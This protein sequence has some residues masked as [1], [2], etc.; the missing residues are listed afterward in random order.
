MTTTNPTYPGVYVEEASTSV[1]A[2]TAAPTAVTAFVGHTRRGPLNHPVTVT[3]FAEFERHF[4]RLTKNSPVGYAVHQYFGN[5]GGSAVV[6]R[7]IE[8]GSAKAACRTLHA[9]PEHDQC[10]VLEVRA[11][12]PGEWGSVLRIVVDYPARDPYDTF[13]LRVLDAR[14]R[15][16]ERFR[17]L[18]MDPD[19]RRYVAAVVNS[20]STLIRVAVVGDHRPAPSGTVSRVFDDELPDLDVELTVAIGDVKRTFTLY[21]PDCDGRPPR[22]LTELALLLE[23]KLRALPDRPRRHAF[24]RAQVSRWG[25]RLRT[26][27]GSTDERDVVRFSGDCTGD[28]GLDEW[29]SPPAVAL[30]G[31]ADGDLP[32]PRDLIGDEAGKTGIQALRDV[33]DVNLLCLP[34]LA[35]YESADD[36]TAVLSAAGRLC[37]ERRMFM[38]VDAPEDWTSVDAARAGI[39]EFEPV[40]DDHSALFFPQLMLDDPLTG[41]LRAFPPCGAVAGVIARTDAERGVWKAAA[42]IG[43]RLAGVR[44]LTVPLSDRENGLL[45]PLGINCLRTFPGAGPVVWGARTLVDPDPAAPAGDDA[46]EDG[47]PDGDWTHIPVRRLALH[48]EESLH[49]GLRWVV[50]EPNSEQLWQQ[51]RLDCSAY[52]DALF[53]Q[54]AFAGNAP[55]TAYFVKCDAETT[56]PDDIANG[57]VNVVV[58]IAPVRPAEFVIV[59]IQQMTGQFEVQTQS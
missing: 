11:I 21:D 35:G 26:V 7:V 55:R 16:R 22:N 24:A 45:N 29:V 30:R 14:G 51:I 5:G 48:V 10:P 59:K 20:E 18:S 40:R 54:G 57:V 17:G 9:T 43:A 47:A 42:G 32:T 36:R 13:D 25:R 15:T 31:G 38:L 37:R 6:V 2:V 27:A 41:R 4:G 19:R 12:E 44:A 8:E 46:A 52:L 39:A 34:E 33:H 28:L 53:R 23:R 3:S 1:R 49:R 50:F 58:G 56:T